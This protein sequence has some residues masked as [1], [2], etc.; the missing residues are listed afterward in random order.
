VAGAALF[1]V[2]VKDAA[3]AAPDA[4][5]YYV[6]A[7]NGLFL[8]RRTPLFSA[9]VPV[10]GV[11]GL[12]EHEA[13]L[14]L[15]IPRLPRVLLERSL[16]FFRAVYERWE[17]EAIL[18][19]FYAPAL[20]RFVLRAPSQVI[21]GRIVYGRFRADLRLDYRACAKPGPEYLKL[22]T[23]HSHGHLGPTHSSIDMHDELYEAGLHITAGYVDSSLP[24][25]AA[26]FVVGR[27]RFTLSPDDV[28]PRFGAARRPPQSW[29]REVT[30]VC[31]QWGGGW[32]SE[33]GDDTLAR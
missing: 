25:F 24:E 31:Q 11:A 8:E 14:V 2:V 27:T 10:A 17:G 28:L 7:A 29:L 19:L 32:C 6:V 30:V 13:A 22:G 18:M 33:H 15:H 16:G 3:F 26:A 20:G 9:S 12:L 5:S 1:P 4:P 21:T 23:F